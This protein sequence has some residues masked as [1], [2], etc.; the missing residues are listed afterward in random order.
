MARY[1][2]KLKLLA[3]YG[4]LLLGAVYTLFPLAWMLSASLKTPD[5]VFR[6]PVQWIPNPFVWKNYVEPFEW[7]PLG[8]YFFNSIFVTSCVVVG[9]LLLAAL[10][11][12]AFAKFQFLGRNV[13]FLFVLGT[14]MVPLQ[15]IM[16]P[17]FVIVKSLGWVDTYQGLIVPVMLT[18]FGVFFMRQYILAIP[19]ELIDAARIDGASEPLIFLKIVLP[20]CSPALLSLGMLVAIESWDALLWPLITVSSNEM[21][22]LPLG[23]SI[24]ENNYWNPD[25]LKLATATMMMLPLFVAFAVGQKRIMEA[26]FLTG[27]K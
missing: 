21:F 5:E 20:L 22:T 15:V 12:Y 19:D 24:F 7:M 23:L 16:V 3:I 13:G 9:H 27:F 18:A 1:V 4:I 17:L 8:R 25:N 2:N 14:M 26:G 6:V 11:G 10:G